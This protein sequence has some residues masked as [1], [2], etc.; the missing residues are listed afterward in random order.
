MKKTILILFLFVAAG[1]VAFTL[2]SNKSELES[3]AEEA[4]KSSEF[5]PVTLE[6]VESKTMELS[7]ESNGI[8]EAHQELTIMAETGGAV[9]K[10]HKRKGDYV[11]V[12]DLI[13]Q[14]DDRL[15]QAE[16]TIAELNLDQSKKDLQRFTNLM[17][18]DA[19]TKK[20]YEDTERGFKIAEA[21]LKSIQKRAED[22]QIKAPIS[23]YINQ[24]FYEQGTLVSPGMPLAELINS[25]PLKLNL[26]VSEREVATVKLGQKIPVKVNALPN[27]IQEGTVSFISNKADGAFKY[28]V[29]LEIKNPSPEIKPGMFGT[30]TFVSPDQAERL[31][32]NRKSIVGGLK[33]PGVFTVENGVAVYR[34]VQIQPIN[35]SLVEVLEGLAAGDEIIASGLINV[36]AGV[37]VKAQ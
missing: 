19:I 34:S 35:S 24:D 16:L 3:A 9:V 4:M 29:I 17:D 27:V 2:Y 12:G 28:E 1:A 10:I 5:V 15:I 33:N 6:R 36:K 23:G 11:R 22:T 26:Q 21:Q 31:L 7:F 8:F 14:I 32:I 20:Q 37:Q 30:A 18:T 13:L 25:N